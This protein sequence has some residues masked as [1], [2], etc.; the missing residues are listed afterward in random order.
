MSPNTCKRSL[1]LAV[2]AVSLL[3]GCGAASAQIG[4]G[5]GVGLPG[6]RIGVDIPTYPSFV[7]IPGY[8]VYYAPNVNGNLFFYD[9]RYWLFANDNWYSSTWY[10]GPWYTVPP[11][12]VP[13]FL[14][15]VPIRFYRRPP[16]FFRAWSRIGPPHWGV[17]WGRDWQRRRAG[18]NHWNR[19]AMPPRAPLPT[20]QRRYPRGRYPGVAEQRDLQSRNYRYSFRGR[21]PR[22]GAQ[23]YQM[24][25][26]PPAQDRFRG[27]RAGGPREAPRPG[28]RRGRQPPHPGHDHNQ[29]DSNRRPDQH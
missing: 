3:L 13:A 24:E 5:V 4:I 19:A 28:E 15:R 26:H 22:P 12:D 7:P 25:R 2:G 27:H 23:H 16:P 9:G 10:N 1:Y 14:L 6:I 11:L 8:P 17:H 18:W 29:R 20:Y 21:A